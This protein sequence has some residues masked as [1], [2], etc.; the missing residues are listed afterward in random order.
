MIDY[1]EL[2]LTDLYRYRSAELI[3]DAESRRR[4]AAV[5]GVGPLRRMLRRLRRPRYYTYIQLNAA[6][7]RLR[8][9]VKATHAPRNTPI[10]SGDSRSDGSR[11]RNTRRPA[12]AM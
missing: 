11:Q 2:Y 9:T 8:T 3:A 1:G 4:A 5:D 12:Q 10:A 7:G 6:Q